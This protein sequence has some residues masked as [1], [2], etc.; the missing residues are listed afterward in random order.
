MGSL[1]A[2]WNSHVRHL[3][4]ERNRS[5]TKEEIARFWRSKKIKEEELFFLKASY[6]HSKEDK[7]DESE[8]LPP[9]LLVREEEIVEPTLKKHGWWIC[10]KCAFL[11]EP[12]YMSWETSY[13]YVAQ[14]HIAR[15]HIDEQ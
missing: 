3:Q 2:G 8:L 14:F 5:L 4:L 6:R 12:P 10:S 1:M 11:N 13:N 9:S 7:R 15:K